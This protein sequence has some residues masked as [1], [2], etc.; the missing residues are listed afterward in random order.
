MLAIYLGLHVAGILGVLVL[1]KGVFPALDGLIYLIGTSTL[2]TI[3][4]K[5][6]TKYR[7]PWISRGAPV[8]SSPNRD[9]AF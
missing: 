5:V 9:F 1:A 8:P 7:N 4:V 6:T 2:I 3:W